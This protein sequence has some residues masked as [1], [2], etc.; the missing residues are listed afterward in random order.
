MVH[1]EHSWRAAEEGLSGFIDLVLLDSSQGTVLVLEC[2]RVLSADWIFLVPNVE[3]KDT[4]RTKFGMNRVKN[5][6][7]SMRDLQATP[8]TYE[9][10]FC[11]VT[12]DQKDRGP[13]WSAL[14]DFL[15]AATD[16]FA[17]EDRQALVT[18]GQEFRLY[19]S[20]ICNDSNLK[21][22]QFSPRRRCARRWKIARR[23]I[24]RR[25]LSEISKAA[26]P[27]R[28]RQAGLG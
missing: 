7:Y 3:T 21:V 25:A 27:W 18:G 4:R 14:R 13:C 2:K 20:V 5:M 26:L 1:T 8:T 16:A 24:H 17:A 12:G 28:A 6:F 22:C 11:T 10:E 9:S 19:A 15:F 23:V